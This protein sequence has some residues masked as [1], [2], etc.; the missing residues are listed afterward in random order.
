MQSESISIVLPILVTTQ[1]QVAMTAK[2]ISLAREKT[3]INFNLIIVESGTQYFTDYADI[4]IFEKTVTTPERSHNHGW[5]LAD[6]DYVG[7][8]TNDVYVSEGWLEAMVECFDKKHDCGAATLA[9]SQF[10]HQKQEKIEEGNWWSVALLSKKVFDEV[11]YYDER[12][13][14]SWCDTDLL[15]RMYEAGMKMY[16]NFNCVVDHLIGQ[17]NYEKP[18]FKQDYE[19]GRALFNAKHAGCTLPIYEAVR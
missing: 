18:S 19:F 7:L 4:H 6:G 2:C 12:F 8:L 10:G 5:K 3:S 9:S 1:K 11:G 15:V 17:T 14:N 13:R 16:R